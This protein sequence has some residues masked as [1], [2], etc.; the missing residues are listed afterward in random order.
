MNKWESFSH[1]VVDSCSCRAHTVLPANVC[2]SEQAS[3][4]GGTAACRACVNESRLLRIFSAPQS[5]TV[6]A[7]SGLP[8]GIPR[9]HTVLPAN[10]CTSEQA[11]LPGDTA[12]CRAFIVKKVRFCLTDGALANI[13]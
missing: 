6:F 11:S 4:P 9:A 2:T 12:A 3:L 13:I 1:C 7:L 10:V 5:P 8:K